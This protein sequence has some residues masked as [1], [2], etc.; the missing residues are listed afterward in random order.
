MIS[1]ETHT[2]QQGETRPTCHNRSS[3]R[4]KAKINA[5]WLCGE[6]GCLGNSPPGRVA[7]KPRPP[8]TC[9]QVDRKASLCSAPF[10]PCP[11]GACV[12]LF[13]SFGPPSV[14]LLGSTTAP[15]ESPPGI[16]K[17]QCYPLQTLPRKSLPFTLASLGS[18][19]VPWQEERQEVWSAIRGSAPYRFFSPRG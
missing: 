14:S 7:G 9:S 11:V 8:S 2:S 10:P 3:L 1:K 18:T 19:K 4:S 13:T 15:L 12:L 17:A 16:P 5:A 6:G